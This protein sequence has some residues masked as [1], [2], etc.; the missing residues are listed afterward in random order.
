MKRLHKLT[1]FICLLAFS[2]FLLTFSAAAEPA[3]PGRVKNLTAKGGE[4]S[5]TFSW[6]KV[7]TASGYYLY[8]V[9]EDGTYDK[10]LSVDASKNT[11]TLKRIH[12]A[13]VQ[14]GT[15]YTFAVSAYRRSGSS[16]AEGTKSSNVTV[17]PM[18]KKPGTP[19][20]TL[21]SVGNKKV[22][23]TWNKVASATGYQILQKNAKGKYVPLNKTLKAGTTK[24]TVKKL[25]NNKAYSFKI[26]AVRKVN[27]KTRYGSSSAPVSATP[28]YV[29]KVMKGVHTSYFNATVTANVNGKRKDNGKSYALKAGQHVTCVWKS[30]T[31]A[32]VRV[33]NNIDVDVAPGYIHLD[34]FILEN[35]KDYSKKTKEGFINYRGYSSPSQYLVWVSVSRQMFY[36]FTGSQCNWKLKYSWQCSTG[37]IDCRTM[38]GTYRIGRKSPKFDFVLGGYAYYASFFSGNAIHSWLYHFPGHEALYPDRQLSRIPQSHGCVRIATANARW[39]YSNVPVGTTV[40]VY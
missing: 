34:S 9:N 26:R 32:T 3:A 37:M 25:T 5:I 33:G 2:L 20:L 4:S 30:Y 21:S 40:V 27:G 12:G 38:P 23:L 7:S 14:N 22:T 31:H 28:F 36:L 24:A 17:R 39:I 10:L 35:D 29:N 1:T 11:L 19:S 8:L 6:K 15:D 16:E 13:S 18:I